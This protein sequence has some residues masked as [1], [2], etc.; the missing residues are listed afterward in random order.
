MASGTFP[1]YLIFFYEVWALQ[2][3]YRQRLLQV[4]SLIGLLYLKQ[5]SC[6]V[7]VSAT[8]EEPQCHITET[9][10][11]NQL[12]ASERNTVSYFRVKQSGNKMSEA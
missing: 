1:K 2:T 4:H 7:K 6:F 3:N 5:P 8:P 10:F 12:Q 9:W 11:S